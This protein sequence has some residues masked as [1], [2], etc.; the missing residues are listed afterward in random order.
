MNDK[1]IWSRA[2]AVLVVVWLGCLAMTHAIAVMASKVEKA[3]VASQ[4]ATLVATAVFPADNAKNVCPDM[5][6]RIT[7]ASAAIVGDGEIQVLDASNDVL[8]ETINVSASIRSKSIGGL[9]NFNYHSIIIN[10]HVASIYLS[11]ALSY[12]KTYYVK[13]DPRAFKSAVGEAFAGFTDSKAWRF[14]TRAKPPLAGGKRITVAADGAGDFAT[15]QGALDFVPEG[16]KAPITIFIRNGTYNE[17]IFFTG[18]DNLTILGE[19]RRKTIITYAN[20]DRFNNNAGGNP[21]ATGTPLPGTLPARSGAVYRRGLFLAHRVTNLTIANLTL[22][23]TTPQGGSQAE[24]LILNGTPRA[25]AIIVNVDLYSFQD[26]LQINGQAYV[27]NCYIEGDVDFMW[28]TGPVFFENCELKSLRSGAYFTQVRNPTSNHG[29]VFKNC[30]FEGAP[31]I[32]GNFLSRVA[33]ARFPASEVVLIDCVL[34]DAVGAVG[35]RLDQVT[36]PAVEA[37]NLHYWEYNSHDSSGR[38]IDMR[39]RL[40]IARQL[41]FPDD[42]KTIASYGDAK[43][44][45]GDEWTPFLAPIITTQPAAV[46]VNAGEKVILSVAVAAVPEPNYQWQKSGKNITGATQADYTIESASGWDAGSYRVVISNIAGKAISTPA[47]VTIK[48]WHR[49]QSVIRIGPVQ[50]QT[51][52]CATI[53]SHKSSAKAPPE[54]LQGT[55]S[56]NSWHKDLPSA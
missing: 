3:P 53:A 49:L 14:S 37:P 31:G 19:D 1:Y 35:W 48:R 18:K 45:L 41:K 21:F 52:I 24:A 8:V 26:T 12:G 16:N 2:T 15:V 17:I 4:Q 51:E 34:T 46:S 47:K 9:P 28:G 20:N 23:N 6:L 40:S 30:T 7:F 42:G 10:D 54:Q 25:R 11:H 50:S 5:P 29:Y 55:A 13:I 22:H 39:Q 27:D 36:Q 32:T 43:F 56:H 44:V 33:P 38:P